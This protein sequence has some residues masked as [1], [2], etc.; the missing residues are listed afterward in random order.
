MRSS[1]D[2][3]TIPTFDNSSP[4]EESLTV[5]RRT[6]SPPERRQRTPTETV[7]DFD[8]NVTR[9]RTNKLHRSA[10]TRSCVSYLVHVVILAATAA[11]G[12]TM[13][14]ISGYGSPAFAF[15]CSF[16]S[17]AIGAFIPSPKLKRDTDG[18]DHT[19]SLPPNP[20]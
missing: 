3:N 6:P 18:A 17:F 15:W 5:G 14:I 7:I 19:G 11:T 16:F 8:G 2:H 10:V 12:L 20:P 13:A 1:S 9:L 4:A